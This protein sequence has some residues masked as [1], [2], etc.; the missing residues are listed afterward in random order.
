[1]RRVLPQ[2]EFARW[3]KKFLPGL[4]PPSLTQKKAFVLEPAVVAD[5]TDPRLV[6]LDGL[7]LSR[8]WTLRGI[9]SALPAK[10]P[11]RPILQKAAEEHARAGL[12]R[13]SSGN[14]EGEHWLA[15][16]AVYLLTTEPA[17]LFEPARTSEPARSAG[18]SNF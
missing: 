3:L 9:A 16:F 7:N 11:R 10:D 17:R 8:A 14:Y 4:S 2:E 18:Q 6:H 1:M 5:P 12:A 15:S 13:V